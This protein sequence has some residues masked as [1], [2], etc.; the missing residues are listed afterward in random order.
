MTAINQNERI[1]SLDVIRGFALIGILIA[2]VYAMTSLGFFKLSYGIP[3]ADETQLDSTIRLLINL[4][5]DG[6]FVSTFS[7]LFGVGFYIFMTRAAQKGLPEKRLF[8]RRMAGLAVFGLL[9]LIFFWVGDILFTYALSGI[10]LLFFLRV[11][12]KT[13]L[14]WAIGLLT[15]FFLIL[16]S[17]AL[18]PEAFLTPMQAQGM[19]LISQAQAAYA[20]GI[21]VEWFRFRL[22]NEVSMVVSGAPFLIPYTLGLFLLGFYAAKKEIFVDL[23]S[24]RT[25]FKRLAIIGY[26]TAIPFMVLLLLAH[27]A[28]LET[29][30]GMFLYDVILRIGALPLALGYMAT[31]VLIVSA[32]KLKGLTARLGAMGRIALTNY[33]MHTVLIVLF[34]QLTGFFGQISMAQNMLIVA[35]IIALQLWLSPLYLSKYRYGPMEYIWRRITYGKLS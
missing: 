30:N 1:A 22:E 34:V 27:P 32:G 25:L 17:S 5:V 24:K 20:N 28:S 9:H 7:F 18:T 3:V 33:L 11:K 21:S 19:Q 4:F 10:F 35:V 8:L 12:A 6:S 31:L 15:L 13:A 14:I 16:A 2:N 29:A 26:I 23:A